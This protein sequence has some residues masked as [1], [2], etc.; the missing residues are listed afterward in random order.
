VDIRSRKKKVIEEPG[1]LG[2]GTDHQER[3]SDFAS[4]SVVSLPRLQ[5]LIGDKPS[6]DKWQFL[7]CRQQHSPVPKYG[8]CNLKPNDMLRAWYRDLGAIL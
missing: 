2:R 3:K 7:Y 1:V 8:A 4:H 5:E 6:Y